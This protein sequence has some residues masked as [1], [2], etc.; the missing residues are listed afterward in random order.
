VAQPIE[1]ELVRALP[2]HELRALLDARARLER[3]GLA[4]R[5]TALLGAPI[6]R[7]LELLP[8]GWQETIQRA[9]RAALEQALEVALA[10]LDRPASAELPSAKT[11]WHRLAAGIS[12][13]AGGALG[14][15]ALP[16]ELPISTVV[17]LRGIADVAR[18]QGEDL[19]DME[20][21]LACLEVFALGGRARG[22]DA[23]ETGYF[24]VRAALGKAV[25][26]A[27]A[28]AAG[29]AG[30]REGAPVLGRLIAVIAERFGVVVGEKAA[31]TLVP[32][33]G[34]LGG[35]AVNV[36]FIDHF[37]EVARGHFGVRRLE[38]IYGARAV[39]AA[40]ATR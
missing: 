19:T 25:S 16:I 22:D 30:A 38:R 9:T 6:E 8:A 35:A 5:L 32:V 29:R 36:I 33:V 11:S 18:S 26:E 15:V 7:G 39:R 27:A 2:P 4:A 17:L 12:G 14:L 40:W 24:A 34:A 37:T 23:A 10:T 20:A 3:P 28:Y 13:A 1:P 21:R 31:A